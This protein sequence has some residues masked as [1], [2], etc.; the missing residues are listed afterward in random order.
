MCI[1]RFK[2][3]NFHINLTYR[4]KIHHGKINFCKKKKKTNGNVTNFSRKN[5]IFMRKQFFIQRIF[6]T[7]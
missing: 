7:K 1:P 4:N 6:E 3:S 2:A 5:L